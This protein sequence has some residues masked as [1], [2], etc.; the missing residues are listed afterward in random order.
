VIRFQSIRCRARKITQ[1]PKKEL[2]RKKEEYTA[3]IEKERAILT[4]FHSL[5]DIAKQISDAANAPELPTLIYW[6]DDTGEHC[7]ATNEKILDSV[8]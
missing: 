8:A 4:E 2:S 6:H 7:I 1:S 5:I 3:V